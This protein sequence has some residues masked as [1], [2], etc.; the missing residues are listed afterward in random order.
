M[1]TETKEDGSD[2]DRFNPSAPATLI[3][4]SDAPTLVPHH[5]AAFVRA[6]FLVVYR[7]SSGGYNKL[8]PTFITKENCLNNF[9]VRFKEF[10][11]DGRDRPYLVVIA[12]ACTPELL[13][14]VKSAC[15]TALGVARA[16]GTPLYEI[17]ETACGNGAGSFNVA[18]NLLTHASADTLVYN[19]EDDYLHKRGAL[20]LLGEG[21]GLFPYVTLYD[22]PDKYIDKGHTQNE[23]VGNPFIEGGGEATKVLLSGT[24]HW[25]VTNS[26]TMTFAA[27]VRTLREDMSYIRHYTSETFPSDFL[28]F[29]S[30]AA[31][32]KHAVVSPLPGASTHGE[33]ATLCPLT[34]WAA[35]E[36]STH[37]RFA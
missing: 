8:K 2:A 18:L 25:K 28:M 33:T 9:L 14:F 13:R 29:L 10:V 7:I 6:T 35:E 22:H 24:S 11:A 1:A 21:V 36:A 5:P 37:A 12:D 20:K 19:V 34:D 26:S 17:H 27:R 15:D 4:G 23:C 32:C 31:E 30:L 3:R 16:D